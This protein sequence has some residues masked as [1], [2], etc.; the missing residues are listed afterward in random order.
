MLHLR[1][2]VLIF[3]FRGVYYFWGRSVLKALYAT[4]LQNINFVTPELGREFE[5]GDPDLVILTFDATDEARRL[6]SELVTRLK[7][8]SPPVP[9]LIYTFS[10]DGAQVRLDAAELKILSGFDWYIPVNFPAQLLAQTQLLI[11]RS[12]NLLGGSHG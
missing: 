9:L 10:S 4:G 12:R 7:Q 5:L 11:R 8:E 6:L 2:I 1:S 3:S